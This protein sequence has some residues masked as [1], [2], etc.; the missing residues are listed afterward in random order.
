[1]LRRGDRNKAA[2]AGDAIKPLQIVAANDPAHAKAH[3]IAPRI[4]RHICLDEIGKLLRENFIA[5]LTATRRKRWRKNRPAVAPQGT[6]HRLHF[7]GVVVKAVNEKDRIW[8][9]HGVRGILRMEAACSCYTKSNKQ[10]Q[11]NCPA[12][13]AYQ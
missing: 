5:D 13:N 11:E 6:G 2:H 12:S 10:A 3:E 8:M 7:L 4:V 9:R 1:M